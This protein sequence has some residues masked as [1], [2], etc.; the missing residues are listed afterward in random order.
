MN[1]Q[2]VANVFL[3]MAPRNDHGGSIGLL[4]VSIPSAML[5]G[6]SRRVLALYYRVHISAKFP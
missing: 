3:K 5:N 4:K 6:A 1:A 2:L